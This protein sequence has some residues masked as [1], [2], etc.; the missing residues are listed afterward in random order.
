M[1]KFLLVLSLLSIII[2]CTACNQ[3]HNSDIDKDNDNIIENQDDTKNKVE[4]L[5]IVIPEKQEEAQTGETQKVLKL[6]L[7][8]T[9]STQ[10]KSIPVPLSSAVEF[11]AGSTLEYDVLTE[12]DIL[13]IGH[14]DAMVDGSGFLSV[15][16]ARDNANLGINEETDLG[17]YAYRDWYHRVIHLPSAE[18]ISS[19]SKFI[20]RIY[21]IENGSDITVYFDNVCIKDSDGNVIK[22]FTEDELTVT[23]RE[24]SGIVCTIETTDDPMPTVKSKTVEERVYFAQPSGQMTGS[25]SI[26]M[27][28]SLIDANAHPGLYI[29][30]QDDSALFGFRGYSVY[31]CSDGLF[32]YKIGETYEKVAYMPTLGVSTGK[33]I[34]I[35][36]EY[37]GKYLKGYYLDDSEGYEPWHEFEIIDE[38]LTGKDYGVMNMSGGTSLLKRL[39]HEN[40][41]SVT[42]ENSF[43]NPVL[44]VDAPDP[45]MLYYD[46]TYYLYCTAHRY[47]V[48]KSTDLV[49]W[50]YVGTCVDEFTWD[51]EDKD[52][53]APDVE[54]YNGKFYMI[55]CPNHYLGL[56]VADSPEGPYKT[57]GEPFFTEFSIDGHL[58][59]DDDGQAYVYFD[60]EFEAGEHPAAIYGVKLD[61]ETGKIDESS[62]TEVIFPEG[63]EKRSTGLGTTEGPYMLKHNNLYYLVYSGND[64]ATEKYAVGYAVS[65]SP[66]GPFEKYEGNPILRT[67]DDIVGPGHNSF[68]ELPNGEIYIVYHYWSNI[69]GVGGRI[70]AMDK[71][72]FSPTESGID[73]LEFRAPTAS[74]QEKPQL[75]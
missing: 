7:K 14:I 32:L 33:D 50:E 51:V 53:W 11:P 69:E 23:V 19:I 65:E 4:D 46:G 67:T 62:L 41:E 56:A 70:V 35:K 44:A 26:T 59:I 49:N 72:R 31:L 15:S 16:D 54:E 38:N 24:A 18:D 21:N 36:I 73:R 8:S 40:Y 27:T 25:G 17:D 29:G 71:V 74:P 55:V 22:E 66:L 52:W 58:F 43:T 45:D 12:N 34:S 28:V 42:I 6:N 20:Y 48:Y 39:D 47:A 57:V 9:G 68:V 30:N 3:T 37:D 13:G 60:G 2:S 64:Y 1:K 63:W 75:N 61:L 5:N 10:I